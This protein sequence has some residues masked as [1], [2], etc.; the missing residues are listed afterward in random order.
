MSTIAANGHLLCSMSVDIL[1][2]SLYVYINKEDPAHRLYLRRPSQLTDM[3]NAPVSHC[4]FV[5][6]HLGFA[7][8]CS[9]T[10]KCRSLFSLAVR[11]DAP[12]ITGKI[13]QCH[14]VSA[15]VIFFR[16]NVHDRRTVVFWILCNFPSVT[17]FSFLSVFYQLFF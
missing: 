10:R 7:S 4:F 9:V 14:F 13:P 2:Y 5:F 1:F 11:I 3:A 8:T 15:F 17:F 12:S 16:L 6:L